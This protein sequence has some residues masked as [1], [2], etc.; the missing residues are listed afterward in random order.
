MDLSKTTVVEKLELEELVDPEGGYYR[1]TY[2]SPHSLTLSKPNGSEVLRKT[3]TS[4]YFM[5]SKDRQ[6]G[7]LHKNGCDVILYYQLGLPIKFTLLHPDGQ[8]EEKLLGPDISCGQSLHLFAPAG[9]WVGS[10]LVSSEGECDFGLSSEAASPG[11]E[12]EDM[13]LATDV[14]I[15]AHYPQHWD[16]VKHLIAPTKLA[17][18]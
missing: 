6:V 14:L 18:N 7:F 8:L 13:T 17:N 11:F 1:R 16:A 12:Y 2:N 9:V 3:M 15:K 10:M 5:L 4:I